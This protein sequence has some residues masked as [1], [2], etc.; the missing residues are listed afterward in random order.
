MLPDINTHLAKGRNNLIIFRGGVKSVWLTPASRRDAENVNFDTVI[1]FVPVSMIPY[2]IIMPNQICNCNCTIIIILS[3]IK[4]QH[5][6]V[7]IDNN[8]FIAAKQYRF[9]IKIDN[10][11]I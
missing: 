11:N 8:T 9:L 2:T 5:L 10:E 1:K 6:E 3:K 4:Y 7:K